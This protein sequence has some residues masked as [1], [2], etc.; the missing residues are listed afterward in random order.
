MKS[1]LPLV[2]SGKVKAL[3]HIT[4][5]GLLENLPRVL[6]DGARAHVDVGAM[7]LPSLFARLRAGGNVANA[8]MVRTFNCGIGMVAVVAPDE[9]E[10]VCEA[11]AQAGEMPSRIGSIVEGTKGCTVVGDGWQADHDA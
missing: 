9:A 11:L 3:S 7:E 5:G 4:G 2:Q 8:E 10:A 1:L 6:P